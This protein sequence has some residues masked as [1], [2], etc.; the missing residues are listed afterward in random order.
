V[1][2]FL[3]ITDN[4]LFAGRGLTTDLAIDFKNMQFN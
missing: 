4:G 1:P 2:R 3:A